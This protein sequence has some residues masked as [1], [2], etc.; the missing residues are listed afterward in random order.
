MRSK[1]VILALVGLAAGVAGTVGS[2]VLLAASEP[3]AQKPVQALPVL[4]ADPTGPACRALSRK[5]GHRS[6]SDR[7]L[8]KLLRAYRDCPAVV[9]DS[10][11][12]RRVIEGTPRVVT[13]QAPSSG[14]PPIASASTDEGEHE[15]EGFSEEGFE[16]EEDD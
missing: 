8:E 5:V 15:A 9:V 2:R 4:Q 6:V 7:S 14:S 11:A 1:I 10:K 16:H 12:P 13:V 3:A